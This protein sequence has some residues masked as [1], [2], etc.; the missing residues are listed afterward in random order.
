MRWHWVQ[1]KVESGALAIESC[2]DPEQ[3]A[4]VLT[5]PLPRPKH[6]KHVAEMGLATT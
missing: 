3:T 5:K 6:H 1:D 2:Q 4:N